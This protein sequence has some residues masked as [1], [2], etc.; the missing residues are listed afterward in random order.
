LTL[1]FS[2]AQNEFQDPAKLWRVTVDQ[3]DAGTVSAIGADDLGRKGATD[4][5]GR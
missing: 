5:L 1:I 4:A 3:I 2:N